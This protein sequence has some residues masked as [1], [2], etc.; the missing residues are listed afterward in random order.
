MFICRFCNKEY[1]RKDHLNRHLK[2]NTCPVAKTMTHL[3][4]HNKLDE[5]AKVVVSGNNNVVNSNNNTYNINLAIQIQPI[6]K[7]S[8]D[9]I[10]EDKMKTIID[11]FDLN[12][13]KLNY[14]L[15]DYLNIV[16]CDKNHPEN[17]SVKYIKKYPPVFNST[18]ED[19]DG[20][21]ITVIKSLNDTCEL[22][23]DPVLDILKIK[24]R[25]CT[26]KYKKE[27]E[28]DLDFNE[29]IKEL[30]RELKKDNIKKILNNFLKNDLINNIEMKLN[31]NKV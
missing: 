1:T 11:K 13:E 4:F 17:H 22:L 15:T 20:N 5:L 18:V 3:D 16:L 30:R 12:P 28:P 27:G 10:T 24:L 31:V 23:T 25:E 7:L 19:K 2:E 14:L 8:L 29:A 26:R 9:H 6:N 21:M